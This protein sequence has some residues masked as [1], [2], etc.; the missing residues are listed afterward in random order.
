MMNRCKLLLLWYFCASDSYIFVKWFYRNLKKKN[1]IKSALLNIFF[2]AVAWNSLTPSF[3]DSQSTKSNGIVPWLL[4]VARRTS[5]LDFALLRKLVNKHFLLFG[6]R[7]CFLRPNGAKSELFSHLYQNYS[8][9]IWSSLKSEKREIQQ[10][11]KHG[12][13]GNPASCWAGSLVMGQLWLGKV[14]WAAKSNTW[15]QDAQSSVCIHSFKTCNLHV[16]RKQKA[17][18][19]DNLGLDVQRGKLLSSFIYVSPQAPKKSSVLPLHCQCVDCM[20]WI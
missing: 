2:G 1:L 12:V 19:A 7:F 18:D 14:F 20:A 5:N 13:T 6:S 10:D 3:A 17:T 11:H 8:M 9:K 4:Y 15:Q 16:K